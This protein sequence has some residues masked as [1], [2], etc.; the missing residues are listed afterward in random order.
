MQ[1]VFSGDIEVS[2]VKGGQEIA[3]VVRPLR[4]TTA[5]PVIRFKRQFWRV[6]NG[7][8]YIDS[9]P[10]R[11]EAGTAHP[12]IEED[13]EDLLQKA[14]ITANASARLLVDA[15]PGTGKT[16]VACSRV[17]ALIRN[18]TPPSRIWLISFTR[19][20]IQEIRNR[21]ESYLDE[22]SDAA[23]V[24][25][26]TLDSHAWSIQSGFSSTTKL[27]GSHDDNIR[28]TLAQVLEDEDVREY[29]GRVGHLVVDEAQDITGDRAS[30]VLAMIDTI[31][32]DCGVTVFCDQAQAIY[33]FTEESS[34]REDNKIFIDE[35]EQRQFE[36]HEL[37]KVHRTSD[38]ALLKIFTDVRQQVLD[39]RLST[40]RKTEL[41][42]S[43]IRELA[44][45]QSGKSWELD[46]AGVPQNSLV[47][48]RQRADVLAISAKNSAVPHRLRMS[49]LPPRILPSFAQLFWDFTRGCYV[50]SCLIG[51]VMRD[52]TCTQTVSL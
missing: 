10:V 13:E 39:K 5:G 46:M 2:I 15:G 36:P 26:A 29:L 43:S 3:R 20:A 41:V 19:T 14:V 4:E 16:F 1:S 12:A 33:G 22:P 25:I 11:D 23:A 52:G 48:V 35:L 32:E 51:A 47:L 24:K 7:I 31:D 17:A 28:S 18:G 50:L 34:G 40:A 49:G 27:T 30:L 8:V 9:G 37:R 45:K 42:S 21:L 38:P 44:A 6:A